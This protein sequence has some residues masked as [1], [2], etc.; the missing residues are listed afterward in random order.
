MAKKTYCFSMEDSTIWNASTNKNYEIPEVDVPEQ[1]SED[2]Y[3]SITEEN[4][5]TN[6]GMEIDNDN[7][8]VKSAK[9]IVD[10]LLCNDEYT[11]EI[12]Q[13]VLKR[14]APLYEGSSAML[15]RAT[16]A[17]IKESSNW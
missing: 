17:L 3:I 4:L 15:I 16:A 11:T 13:L 10:I 14:L 12:A 2:N 7:L 8:D 6:L 5:I 1:F 9:K